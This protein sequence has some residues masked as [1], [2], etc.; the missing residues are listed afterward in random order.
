MSWAQGVSEVYD[1]LAPRSP[2]RAVARADARA[3]KYAEH[4]VAPGRGRH[5]PQS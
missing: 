1:T 5:H 2:S 3:G 4:R